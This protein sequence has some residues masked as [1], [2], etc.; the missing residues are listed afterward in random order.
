[1]K[2]CVSDVSFKVGHFTLDNAGNN[3][4][5]MRH[6]ETMLGDRDIA[7]DAVDRKIM[8]FAH[9]VD[10]SSKQVTRNADNTVDD[11]GDGSL[12]SDE[13]TAISGPITRGRNVV[14]V[15]RGSGMRRD[16]FEEVIKDGNKRGWFK[17]GRPL[18]VVQIKPLQLLRDVRTRW[19]SIYLMLN[20]LH[21]MRPVR[22]Y[23]VIFGVCVTINLT[24]YRSLP[25]SSQQH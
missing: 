17:A 5:M 1:M 20:R 6:L 13:E 10:L 7:F 4:T 21:E 22:L 9:V 23:F 19:D 25:R 18:K 16:A 8:C 24:G 2:Q 15:I 14:R 11:D 3:G 12:E